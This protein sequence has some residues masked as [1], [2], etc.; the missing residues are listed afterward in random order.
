MAIRICH[1]KRKPQLTAAVNTKTAR[2]LQQKCRD[3]NGVGLLQKKKV[4]S[5][6]LNKER[7]ILNW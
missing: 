6:T 3:E 7:N 5:W 1:G 2:E 4:N